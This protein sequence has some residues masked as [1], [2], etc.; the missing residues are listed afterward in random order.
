MRHV[1]RRFPPGEPQDGYLRGVA[2]SAVATL[3]S[4]R[5]EPRALLAGLVRAARE[6]RLLVYSAHPA[7][8]RELAASPV[9]GTVPAGP[10]PYAFVV[11]NNTAANKMDYYLRRSVSYAGAGCADGERGSRITVRF[12]NAA[13]AVAR[14]P[15]Y[16]TRRGDLGARTRIRYPGRGAVVVLVSVYGPRGAGV[17]RSTLDGRPLPV[18][19]LLAGG[20]PVWGFPLVVPPGEW[21]TVVLDIREPASAAAPM[22]PVQPLVQPQQVRTTLAGCQ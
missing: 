19:S 1:Y 15:D 13:A 7:E 11:V 10:G 16:V 8:Q 20:R 17:I 14:L 4:G 18:S 12:G 6:R 5:G 21:R 22:V 3:L 2:R 9:G